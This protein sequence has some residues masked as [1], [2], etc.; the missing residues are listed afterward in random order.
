ASPVCPTCGHVAA[1]D[2]RFCGRC[3]TALTPACPRCGR[4]LAA[5][6]AL[7]TGCGQPLAG[8]GSDGV[9][10]TERRRVSVLFIDAVGSTPYAERA[11]PERVRSQ[12]SEFYAA[13]RRIV[14]QYGGVV[15][16]YIGDAAMVLFGAPVTTEAHAVRCL[17]APLAPPRAAGRTGG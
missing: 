12:Q 13:V 17:R 1:P 8:A 9:G 14:R 6:V 11:D 10:R 2:D 7:C 4:L 3:G 5:D 16:K 15:E